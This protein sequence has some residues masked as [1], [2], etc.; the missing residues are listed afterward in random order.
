MQALYERA[1]E[2]ARRF[3][4]RYV[5]TP[6]FEATE[7]FARTSGDTSDIVSKEMYTFPDRKGRSLTLRPEGTA[8]VMRAWLGRRGDLG[9]PFKAYYLTRM[10]RYSRPQAGRYREHRQFG[11]ELIGVEGPAADVEV[12]GVGDAFLRGLGLSRYRVEVNSIGDGTCRPAYR[13]AL[14][15]YLDANVER[16]RDDHRDHYRENPLR[17]LDCKD[18]ACAAVA[19]AAPRIT[20]HLCPACAEHL[21]AVLE[22]IRALGIEPRVV[23]TLVRGMDYYTRTAFEFVSEVLSQQQGTLFGG[24]RYDGLAEALGGPPTPGIGFGMGLERVALALADEG[25]PPPEEPVLGCFVVAMGEVAEGVARGLVASIRAAGLSADMTLEPRPMK[26]QLKAADH[27]GATY[28]AIVGEREVSEG[29]V[30]LK[31][32]ADGVQETL[33]VDAVVERVR[34]GILG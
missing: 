23:P 29:T 21:E 11:I 12:I 31:R 19:A 17:V 4:Y 9:T 13:D 14:I 2:V 3:G 34:E 10:Y 28:A 27:A 24:G 20:E 15:A 18:E 8:P 26:A 1:A 25:V 32:L 22:G 7:V 33:P 5:E 6:V 16:L 30:T